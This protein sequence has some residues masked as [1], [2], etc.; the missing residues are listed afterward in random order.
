MLRRLDTDVVVI[1]LSTIKAKLAEVLKAEG[2]IKD[3]ILHKDPVQGSMTLV[4]RFSPTKEPRHHGHQAHQQARPASATLTAV[5]IPEVLNGLRDRDSV[6]LAR[7][8][9]GSRRQG[10]KAWAAS[11]SARFGS[12]TEPAAVLAETKA[13]L[14][15]PA[16]ENNPSRFPTR[17]KSP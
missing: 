4:L 5:E 7:G 8:V 15:C 13:I 14:R 16:L 17:S 10:L 6:D 9:G 2:F 1:P 12:L 3:F 11:C